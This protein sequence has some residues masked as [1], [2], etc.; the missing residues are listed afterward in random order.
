[1]QRYEIRTKR[2]YQRWWNRQRDAKHEAS[3]AAFYAEHKITQKYSATWISF[4]G[5]MVK[6]E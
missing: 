3:I 1:V 2:R 4:G 6:I 5:P